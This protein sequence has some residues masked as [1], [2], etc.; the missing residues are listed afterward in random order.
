MVFFSVRM[1]KLFIP[2]SNVNYSTILASLN[3]I[4]YLSFVYHLCVL[5]TL[6]FIS[7]ITRR[8]FNPL[9][10][11]AFGKDEDDGNAAQPVST[12]QMCSQLWQF[13]LGGWDFRLVNSTFICGSQVTWR[14]GKGGISQPEKKSIVFTNVSKPQGFIY[15]LCIEHRRRDSENPVFVLV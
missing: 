1:L 6:F 3:L 14:V 13:E 15:P 5:F 4:L 7:Y 11:G 9:F 10:L 2:I 12:T 8:S